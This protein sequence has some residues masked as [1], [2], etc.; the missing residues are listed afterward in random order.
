MRHHIKDYPSIKNDQMAKPTNGKPRPKIQG[1]VFT[2]IE[3]DAEASNTV[4]TCIIHLFSHNARVL[5]DPGST[6]SFVFD[7]LEKYF[8]ATPEP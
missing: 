8:D 2:M 1:C 4:V 7:N 3:K 6:H 5:T